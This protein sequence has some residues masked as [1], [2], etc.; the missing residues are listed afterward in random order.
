MPIFGRKKEVVAGRGSIPTERI[1][2]LISEG[3]A[4]ETI[5]DTLKKEGFSAEEIDKGLTGALGEEVSEEVKPEEVEVKKPAFAPLF[6]KLD[7]YRQ[8]LYLLNEL[9]TTMVAIKN[10]FS[11]LAEVD[12]LREEN[13]KLIKSAIDKVDKRL[14]SLDSEFLRPSGFEEEFPSETYSAESLEGVVGDLKGQVD[15]LK[16]ELESMD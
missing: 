13:S 15:Q 8:I 3:A 16:T 7:R 5:I 4:Q 12:R 11:I 6:V 10:A 2:T 14:T 1:K 9:R